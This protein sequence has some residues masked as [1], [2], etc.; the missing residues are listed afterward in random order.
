MAV[1]GIGEGRDVTGI[2]ACLTKLASRKLSSAPESINAVNGR[3][4]VLNWSVAEIANRGPMMWEVDV[5]L[6]RTPTLTCELCLLVER[7]SWRGNGWRPHSIGIRQPEGAAV[8]L[9]GTV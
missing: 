2:A 7:D 5:G 6:A 3:D 9:L 8:F 1:T 4:R